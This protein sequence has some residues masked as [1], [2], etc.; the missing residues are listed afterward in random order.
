MST[1][2]PIERRGRNDEDQC[3]DRKRGNCKNETK[4]IA[5]RVVRFGGRKGNE[6][7]S[8]RQLKPFQN[9]ERPNAKLVAYILSEVIWR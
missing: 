9:Q 1:L 4:D 7:R 6:P 3:T 2:L 8:S 5:F